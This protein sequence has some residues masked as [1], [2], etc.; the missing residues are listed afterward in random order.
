MILTPRRLPTFVLTLL[1]VTVPATGDGPTVTTFLD[2]G[3]TAHRGNSAEYPEN[4]I[5][6]FK[7]GIELGADWIEL[8]IF[9]SRDGKLVVIHDR[10][11]GRVGDKNLVVPDA[12]YEQLL[13]VD[14]ATEFRKR[15]GDAIEAVPRHTIPLLED[16]LLLVMT[17]SKTRVSIQ[18]KMDCVA[19]AI[20]LVKELG[21]ERWVGFND[22]NLQ[23]MAEVKRL[24]PDL[25]VFWDRSQSNIDEDIR[26]AKQHG[27]EA[28][29]LHHSIVTKRNIEQIQKA[30][31]EVGAW[32]VNDEATMA[33]MLKMGIDR[34]YTDDPRRL[35][36]RKAK[37]AFGS[38]VLLVPLPSTAPGR[39]YE[40]DGKISR[41]VLENYLSR[42]ITMLDLLTGHGNVKDNTRMLHNIGAKFAG[43][44]IY[45]WGGESQLPTRLA[46]AQQHA[47]KI[48]AV[49]PQMILQACVFEIVSEDVDKL[50]VPGWAFEAF[51]Q[52]PEPRKFRYEAMLYP[53]GRG[54]NHWRKG[55]SIP[56]ISQNETK[57]WFYFLAASYI[58][59]GCEA[60]H[61]GQAEIMDGNDPDHR[62]WRELLSK[63]R[64]YAARHARRR[65]VLCDAHVPSG[66]L[67]CGDRL[68]FDFH[69]FPLRIVEVPERPQ[70]G[71]LKMG[72]F[73]SIYGRSKGGVAPSGW[74]CEHL[75]YLVELDNW[76][77]SDRPGQPHV[78][79][80]WVWGYDEI[81]WFAHQDEAYRNQ[82]LG[83][84]WD[85]V[86]EHDP[87]GYFQMPG[88][89]ILHSPVN[90]QHWYYANT[91]SEPVPQG[92]SQEQ[93][94]KAIW[95]GDKK[96][97]PRARRG[98]DP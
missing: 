49:D 28:L 75:P 18:P 10:T 66:G 71:L 21:A 53:S 62:H 57:L 88:S 38:K 2:N 23:Y 78:G 3:V 59:A 92:F 8:D 37:P 20:A 73:D 65:W 41:R 97:L 32:T 12:T 81:S 70:E 43:R 44:T 5:P 30:G 9:R 83:Y 14:V 33:R 48:H 95:A 46:A 90:G 36:T 4:T 86:R 47:P 25:P 52:S 79:G 60:I 40:F 96:T 16:V 54:H 51:G 13:S 64:G 72:A 7:S 42:S 29:V 87:H 93:T 80:C 50:P 6:A 98:Y 35:L 82:W 61:F 11:T 26:T 89:R 39:D 85:W 45:L 77:V 22:G 34:L 1:F 63:V 19:E 91:R 24:A 58:D 76:G 84:A 69:S 56:D 67:L 94:I 17:Q 68:L 15:H 27:F 74:Q 55:S 31:M